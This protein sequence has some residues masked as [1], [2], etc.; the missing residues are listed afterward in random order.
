M[1]TLNTALVN[2]RMRIKE[3]KVQYFTDTNLVSIIN[4]YIHR[5]YDL[6]KGIEC[7]LIMNV[8]EI[9][10]ASGQTDYPITDFAGIVD[11][12]VLNSNRD[13]IPQ[14]SEFSPEAYS[15]KEYASGIQIFNGVAGDTII[16]YSW[17]IIPELDVADRVTANLPF[18]GVWNEAI[19]RAVV[20]ECQEIREHDNSR[21]SVFAKE[22]ED[23]ALYASC[24]RY[25][26]IT[27]SMVGSL[28]V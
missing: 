10:L 1:G 20:V 15:Y 3:D 11:H 27:R 16:V 7:K 17:Q 8:N 12:M 6:M 28:H 4:D 14:Y 19:I 23:N 24:E 21:T 13:S 22:A 5:A 9:T 26:L 25:G 2:I 18:N